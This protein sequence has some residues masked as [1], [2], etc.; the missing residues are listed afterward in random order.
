MSAL[1]DY[2]AIVPNSAD[3]P[4]SWPGFPHTIALLPDGHALND[5]LATPRVWGTF[6]I[7]PAS[8]DEALNGAAL[9]GYLKA[10]T[11]VLIYARRPRDLRP[12]LRQADAMRRRGYRIEVLS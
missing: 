1:P 4:V 3:I 5:L 6:L 9:P 2:I 7:E 10:R 11:P 8:T 12:I